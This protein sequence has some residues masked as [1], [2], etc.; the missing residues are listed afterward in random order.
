MGATGKVCE[1]TETNVG[2]AGGLGGGGGGD[3]GL[4]VE[5]LLESVCAEADS[6]V[7]R[8]NCVPVCITCGVR[9]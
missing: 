6:T 1:E 7:L 2:G 4:G 8:L 9:V 5:R 3:R